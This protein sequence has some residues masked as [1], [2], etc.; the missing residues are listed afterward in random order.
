MTSLN[1]LLDLSGLSHAALLHLSDMAF[2][3][4]C[5]P[6]RV[7]TAEHCHGYSLNMSYNVI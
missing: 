4:T 6:N 1:R 3:G 2:T 7:T 5:M